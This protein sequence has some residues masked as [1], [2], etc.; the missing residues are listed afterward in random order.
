MHPNEF[1]QHVKDNNLKVVENELERMSHWALGRAL[2]S[3]AESGLEDMTGCLLFHIGPENCLSYTFGALVKASINGHLRVVQLLLPHFPLQHAGRHLDGKPL[4]EAAGNGQ[5]H[6]VEFLFP[7]SSTTA[8]Q[9]AMTEACRESQYEV[10]VYL[11]DKV[12]LT[13]DE[14]EGFEYAARMA[15]PEIFALFEPIIPTL[16]LEKRIRA[17]EWSCQN[18]TSR[19][20]NVIKILLA[21]IPDDTDLSNALL[22]AC[23]HG[24][25]KNAEL[26]YDRVNTHDVLDR[27]HGNHTSQYKNWMFF[28]ELLRSQQQKEVLENEIK[29]SSNS[30][31]RKKL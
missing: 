2:E 28:D 27:L 10:V 14:C 23:L 8:Q 7:H 29:I 20:T 18:L 16:P 22:Y 3:A 5:L 30:P 19:A 31:S 17:L 13:H 26:L 6:V 11:M 21:H 15:V 4:Y 9:W 25:N 1:L 12:D 24:M